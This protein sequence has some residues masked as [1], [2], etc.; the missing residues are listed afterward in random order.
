[1]S[2]CTLYNPQGEVTLYI[3]PSCMTF[4]LN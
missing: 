1:M 3:N 2:T 4:S